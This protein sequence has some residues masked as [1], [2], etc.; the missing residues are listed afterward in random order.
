MWF[1]C[2]GSVFNKRCEVVCFCNFTEEVHDVVFKD[3]AIANCCGVFEPRKCDVEK[4][5][6]GYLIKDGMWG[7]ASGSNHS[8]Y[9]FLGF[10][11]VNE[12]GEVEG[13]A[14]ALIPRKDV[15]VLDDWDTMSMRG[16]GSNSL[17]VKNVF[18][19]DK[20]TTSLSKAVVGEYPSVHLQDQAL[21]TVTILVAALVLLAPR[22]GLSA[23]AKEIFLKLPGRRI[24][25]TFHNNQA[26]AA[27]TH[28]QLAEA[29]MKMETASLL[30]Y[31]CADEIDKW[32][33]SGEYMDFNGRVQARVD[34]SYANRLN[35]EKV[36]RYYFS[37]A[38][39]SAISELNLL[40]KIMKDSKTPPQHGLIVPTTG[41]ELYGRILAKQEP[42]TF[43]V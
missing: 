5:E 26:E 3:D 22:I 19:P 31:R 24:Q 34:S 23:A 7:F 6:G 16:T 41:L 9:F 15:N 28:L 25:Y 36:S 21:Y 12:N 32:A 17:T 43:L 4:V 14:A 37:L 29:V 27:I 39:G 33:A 8:D 2:L 1:D 18:V 20:W 42:N 38:G 40:S 35:C 11:Q 30:A 10:P 13:L